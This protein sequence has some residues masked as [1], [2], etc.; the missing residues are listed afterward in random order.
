MIRRKET[1]DAHLSMSRCIAQ[2]LDE[3]LQQS[4]GVSDQLR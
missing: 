3:G 4:L 2:E 1:V